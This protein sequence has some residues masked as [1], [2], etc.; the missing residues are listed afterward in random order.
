MYITME[1][2]SNAGAPTNYYQKIDI[3]ATIALI[4]P[5]VKTDNVKFRIALIKDF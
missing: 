5:T 2:N 4:N 3:P 1:H